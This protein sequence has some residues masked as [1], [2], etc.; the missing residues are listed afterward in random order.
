M[1][2]GVDE[3]KVLENELNEVVAYCHGPSENED[4]SHVDCVP[5]VDKEGDEGDEVEGQ[6]GDGVEV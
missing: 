4:N 5:E 3:P 1:V 6:G 2:Y